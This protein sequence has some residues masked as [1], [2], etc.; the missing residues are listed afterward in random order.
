VVVTYAFFQNKAIE[1]F[2]LEEEATNNEPPLI[3]KF[4]ERGERHH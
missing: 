1:Y 4:P 2:S 3:L